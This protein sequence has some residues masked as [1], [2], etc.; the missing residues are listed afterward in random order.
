[1]VIKV[2]FSKKLNRTHAE[3]TLVLTKFFEV[4]AIPE[5]S[6]IIRKLKDMGCECFPASLAVKIHDQDAAMMRSSGIGVA[7]L[8]WS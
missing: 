8:R 2:M 3:F 4:D 7:K 1:M 6:R 5:K